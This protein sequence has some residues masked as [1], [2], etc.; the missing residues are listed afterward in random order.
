MKTA[1]YFIFIFLFF[2]FVIYADNNTFF[3]LENLLK[4][5]ESPAAL[6]WEN[7]PWKK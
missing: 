7:N 3:N 1:I 6:P 4:K 2:L 5:T